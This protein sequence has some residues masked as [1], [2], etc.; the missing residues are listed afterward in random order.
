MRRRIFAV[1]VA[2]ISA[3]A[4][5]SLPL[6]SVVMHH[7]SSTVTAATTSAKV[8]THR[9]KVNPHDAVMKATL[10]ELSVVAAKVRHTVPELRAE[11]QHVA[12]CE[13]G[14]DWA[15]VGSWYSGIG[16]LNSTWTAYGG[17]K[18]APVAGRATRDQQILIGM[19]VTGGYV[20]DQNGCSPTGW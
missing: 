1:P 17:T 5:L 6:S 11:W 13:V 16:F 14:G 12:I 15:M 8:P 9:A 4:P 20:P 18:Y 3:V 7:H 2:F 10:V 19:K